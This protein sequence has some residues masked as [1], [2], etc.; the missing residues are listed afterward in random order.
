ML[1]ILRVK[2]RW[3]GF[4]GAP[5]YT[6]M[7][8]R[9]FAGDGAGGT[10][11]GAGDA[12]AA[13]AKVR[14]FI[15]VVGS[16]VPP[17]VQ[18]QVEGD[19]DLID[20]ETGELQ[21]TFSV[22]APS[23][24]TGVGGTAYSAASGAV[25]NWRTGGVRRGRRVRGKSFLVPLSNSSYGTNGQLLPTVQSALQ[26]AATTLA[27]STSTPD[28][29]VFTRPSSSGATD[30]SFFVCTGATVPSLAAI[31]RSRRD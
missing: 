26:T 12:A 1:N 3:S 17:V 11:P 25:V 30:G 7:H 16:H 10:D 8:F 29:G 28:L 2:T 18:L 21:D 24:V 23:L 27:G 14:S 13:V 5:G 19:V 22:T 4:N 9:D 15:G 31:L 6:V 20:A